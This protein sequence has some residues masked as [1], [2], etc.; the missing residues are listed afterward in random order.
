[1]AYPIP[2][3]DARIVY[4]D[5]QI[6]VVD[7]PYDIPTS[8]KTLSDPDSLQ[9]WLL[10]RAGQMVW[11]VNQLDADTTGL[12]LFVKEKTLV[13]HYMAALRHPDTEKVYLAIV[14]GEPSWTQRDEHGSIGYV[15]ARSLGVCPDGKT[16]QSRFRLLDSRRKFSLIEARIFSGRTHQIRIH[17]SHLG[18]PVVGDDWYC[19]PPCVRHPRQA[20]HAWRL[21]LAP[22][23]QGFEAAPAPDLRQ[24]AADLDLEMPAGSV[25]TG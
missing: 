20:L 22:F 4:E 21:H 14:H 19:T 15:D 9:Y 5:E 1:M 18:H 13:K 11:V 8:G 7:K 6:L 16:A 3:L 10:E 2:D 17:L 25:E 23:R 24:L 12:N